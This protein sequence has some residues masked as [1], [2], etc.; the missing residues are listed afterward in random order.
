M[1][2]R[3]VWQTLNIQFRKILYISLDENLVSFLY[4]VP[5]VQELGE[6]VIFSRHGSATI[7]IDTFHNIGIYPVQHLKDVSGITFS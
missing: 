4:A 2:C 5:V 1:S 7:G 3:P 6:L